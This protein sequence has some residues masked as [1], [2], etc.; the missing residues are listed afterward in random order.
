MIDKTVTAMAY[1]SLVI[2]GTAMLPYLLKL[3]WGRIISLK[4]ELKHRDMALR[5]LE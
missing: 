1:V 4:K 5:G 2:I 3:A